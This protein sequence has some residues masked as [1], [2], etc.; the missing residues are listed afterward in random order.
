MHAALVRM[1]YTNIKI[2]HTAND[3][4][5]SIA[6][7]IL[8]GVS[9]FDATIHFLKKSGLF[10]FLKKETS[11]KILGVCAGAQVL[12]EASEEGDE[13][14]LGFF[15][16]VVK[17]LAV[18]QKGLKIPHLGWNTVEVNPL[19]EKS[20]FFNKNLSK[21]FYFSHSFRF[22]ESDS[23]LAYVNYGERFP[24]VVC[25]NNVMAVQFHP[26]KSYQQGLEVIKNFCE[27]SC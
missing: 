20:Y 15:P 5:S 8:P 22:P 19:H 4:D 21:K 23:V 3:I 12:F 27:S 17:K 11:R 13:E 7:L 14:G 18:D 10:D 9:A 25:K 16:G 26:E 1:G 24:V 6:T 2:I